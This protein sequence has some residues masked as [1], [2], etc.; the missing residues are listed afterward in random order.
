MRRRI[1]EGGSGSPRPPSQS[2]FQHSPY[3]R[4]SSQLLSD[5]L[6]LTQTKAADDR[7]T[8]ANNDVAT[9]QSKRKRTFGPQFEGFGGVAC[10]SLG[11]RLSPFLCG[12]GQFHILEIDDDSQ[13]CQKARPF[14]GDLTNACIF[15]EATTGL[16]LTLRA[17]PK[18]FTSIHRSLSNTGR[19]PLCSG[20]FAYRA[21]VRNIYFRQF[22]L[23][24]SAN[25]AGGAP[26]RAPAPARSG[27]LPEG[28]S[29]PPARASRSRGVNHFIASPCVVTKKMEE[30][31]LVSKASEVYTP[32]P[33]D[34]VPPADLSKGQRE[35]IER[36]RAAARVLWFALN[37]HGGRGRYEAM[38][39]RS[40]EEALT[41]AVKS[42]THD[43]IYGLPEGERGEVML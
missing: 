10:I 28:V 20:F 26:E 36:V 15:D 14:T 33:L 21:T 6:R 41:W 35:R 13:K 8:P 43:Y 31:K 23:R 2:A 4:H 17:V 9:S 22:T 1:S 40:C 30:I 19:N 27:Q 16:N 39:R 7:T 42:V 38:A 18:G 29:N 3:P 24:S 32:G 12:R 37:D 25:R 34:A 11:L 5:I